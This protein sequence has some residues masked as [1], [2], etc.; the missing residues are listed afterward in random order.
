MHR[1]TRA[2]LSADA[3]ASSH[4]K[5]VALL[6]KGVRFSCAS[7]SSVAIRESVDRANSIAL[8]ITGRRGTR[9]KSQCAAPEPMPTDG[10]VSPTSSSR[11]L[12]S[13]T[14]LLSDDPSFSSSRGDEEESVSTPP[15][16]SPRPHDLQVLNHLSVTRS[17]STGERRCLMWVV[18]SS[19]VVVLRVSLHC[20]GCERKVRKHISNMEGELVVAVCVRIVHQTMTVDYYQVCVTGVTSFSVDSAT[21]KVTVVG[22]VTPSGVL[23]SISKVKKNAR[24]WSSP[25]QSSASSQ[26]KEP[27]Y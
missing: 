4:R 10:S 25:P 17:S 26:L 2:L 13:S 18:R 15:I 1:Q 21:K 20:K 3:T 23:D 8:P 12:L 22:D 5:M 19:Q 7:S 11:Y 14:A 6:S 24:F 27:Y 9:T 16:S